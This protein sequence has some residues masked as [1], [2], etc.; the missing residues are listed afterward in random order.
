MNSVIYICTC[1]SYEFVTGILVL[2]GILI[3][4]TRGL[5]TFGMTLVDD[6]LT[7][8]AY[9]SWT[10]DSSQCSL[11]SVRRLRRPLESGRCSVECLCSGVGSDTPP[12]VA[13]VT[14]IVSSG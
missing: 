1:D 11:C 14:L 10:S 13:L 2:L 9:V 6:T 7:S 4:L 8:G 5:F 12:L 3:S